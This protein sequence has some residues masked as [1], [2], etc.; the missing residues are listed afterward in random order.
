MFEEKKF[1]KESERKGI[2]PGNI[3]WFQWLNSAGPIH[4]MS[5]PTPPHLLLTT[6]VEK[7][8]QNLSLKISKCWLSLNTLQDPPPFPLKKKIFLE[9]FQTSS[10]TDVVI[11][12]GMT[13]VEPILVNKDWDVKNYV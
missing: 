8:S 7:V 6:P 5:T 4:F 2:Y 3:F 9:M 13:V 11:F 10:N 12:S 1:S